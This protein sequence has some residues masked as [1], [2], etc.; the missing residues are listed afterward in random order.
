MENN[1]YHIPVMLQECID[2]LEIK[3][4]GVYVDVT[5]GGAGHSRLIAS[6][7]TTGTLYSFD[8]DD[9]AIANASGIDNLIPVKANFAHLRKFL[10]LH[11][12]TKV[13]GIL[14]DL[15]VSSHQ[16]DCPERGFSY[17]YPE[18]KLDMR[19]STQISLTAADVLN[20]YSEQE[21]HK[22][23]GIYGELKNAKSLASAVVRG[24][25]SSEYV[26]IQDFLDATEDF[27]S[28][29]TRAKY[30]A[31]VFQAL[32]IEVNQE[33]AVLEEML[34]Q[35]AEVLNPG[36]LLVV[37]SYHSLEDRLVKNFIQKGKFKGELEKDF[38]GNPIRPLEQVNRKLIVA[39]DT[40]IARNKRARSAKLRIARRID[41]DK[42]QRT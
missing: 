40:E 18:E 27:I 11:G 29:K 22:I 14:A 31:Q 2:G 35:T 41:E 23:F 17:R 30:L 39:S 6:K 8:Q 9:E 5:L 1:D 7:L 13:D 36:G 3:P 32:R 28:T 16:I 42:W 12:V 15:G 24:R 38:Y 20:T 26:I 21:L 4:E 10:R 19:M 33:M 34:F 37:M 25:I